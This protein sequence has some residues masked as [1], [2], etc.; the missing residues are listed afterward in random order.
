L[1]LGPVRI[2]YIAGV[3]IIISFL[4]SVGPNAG[5]NLAHL[6]GALI[7]FIYTKQLQAGI[8]WGGWI[9]TTLD[10]FRSLFSPSPKVKVS[11]RKK[12][13]RQTKMSGSKK[14]SQEEIDVILDKISE[15]GYESLTK[16]EKQKL[17]NASK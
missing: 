13:E 15:K 4:G 1:F 10:G 7:G 17:F 12:E 2:K 9:T 16:E 8:N 3:Y 6:G 5:G 11:Y 14:A